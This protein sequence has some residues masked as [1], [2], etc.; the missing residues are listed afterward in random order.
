MSSELWFAEGFTQYYGELLLVR[1]GFHTADEY[2]QVVGGL[3]NAVLNTPGA[4]RYPA[5]DMSRKSVFTDAGVSIDP[6]NY[7]NNFTT[8]YYYGGAIAL[9]L[10]LRL[11][12][13]YKLTLDD[14]MREVWLSRGKVMKPYTIPDLQADLAKVTK[15]PKF[16][17]DFFNSYIYGIDKNNYEA[18]LAKA[19]FVLRKAQPGK[20]WLGLSAAALRG[21][22]GQIRAAGSTGF[23][24]TSNALI[25]SPLY[26][27]G[28]DAG[29]T[30]QKADGKDITDGAS[31]TQAIA[32]KKPGDKIT[33]NYANRTGAHEATVTLTE[34][35]SFEVVTTE[36]AGQQPNADQ[37]AF[38]NNWL[39]SKAK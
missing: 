31:L 3:V 12:T 39:S 2:I 32:D 36:K 38:R 14:Y 28:V 7:G 34:N 19:G 22:S 6:N 20:V 9:A 29:D 10:D 33:I 1:A 21:R 16:A 11:R 15:D 27:A 23:T 4:A 18:L 13:D 17:A 25:G 26:N 8:Y 35:P 30:I 5:V 37:T 24:I